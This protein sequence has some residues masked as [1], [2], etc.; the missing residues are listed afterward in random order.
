MSATTTES[1]GPV[2]QSLRIGFAVLQA[3][4]VVLAMYWAASNIRQVPP[5]NQ[6]VVLR[7][8]QVMRVQ[9]A[10]LVLA[11]PRP[12]E[13]VDLL[14]AAQRQ[15]N[16]HVVAGQP[17]GPAIIDPA[18]KSRG[19]LPPPSAGIFLTGDG[20]VVLM[21]ATLSYRIT[22]GAAYFLAAAHVEPA[23]RRLFLAAAV[24]VAAGRPTDDFLVVRSVSATQQTQRESLRAALVDAVNHRLDRLNAA[25]A[26]L[27]IEVTRADVTT[28]LPPAAKLA[29]DAV[30]E[31]SQM[32]D[33]GL[34]V[35]R[36]DAINNRQS[37]AQERDRVLAEARANA[38]ERVGTARSHVAAILALEQRIDPAGRPGLLEQL[39]RER[40]NG[41]LHQAGTIN[42]VDPAGS[43]R[44]ILPGGG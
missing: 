14:P 3:A 27:G 21:D 32:A 38:D 16:L 5:D 43:G 2:A 4:M 41:I 15:L 42:T 31:A 8:G 10:G 44:V 9:P 6:A 11:W 30:L 36:T 19:E 24:A 34:A 28:F 23:L 7:F 25:K 37:A 26:G 20:G 12:F 40:I 39:Y 33:Q 22:D 17:A 13:Q 1:D 29:F 18:S 35:A